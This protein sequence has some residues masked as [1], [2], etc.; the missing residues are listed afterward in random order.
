MHAPG[1]ILSKVKTPIPLNVYTVGMSSPSTAL[2]YTVTCICPISLT[3]TAK[4]IKCFRWHKY[5][6]IHSFTFCIF[7]LIINQWM[8]FLFTFNM[9]TSTKMYKKCLSK[10]I[11][12]TLQWMRIYTKSCANLSK[13]QLTWAGSARTSLPVYQADLL[14]ISSDCL[15]Q[16]IYKWIS[17]IIS[18]ISGMSSC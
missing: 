14:H 16:E 15:I 12:A 11:N 4:S 9:Y 6:P 1:C 13:H 18:M 7:L 2:L 10:S 5:S 17:M 8:T 3:D